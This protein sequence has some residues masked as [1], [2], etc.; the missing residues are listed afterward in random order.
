VYDFGGDGDEIPPQVNI[1]RTRLE[2][3]R[4][5][6]TLAEART[7]CRRLA[8]GRTFGLRNH[9]ISSCDGEYVVLSVRHRAYAA[10]ACPPNALAYENQ[11]KALPAVVPARP[12][13]P[14]PRAR[15]ATETATVVGPAGVEQYVDAFGRIK[16]QFHWDLRGDTGGNS[17]CWVRVAQSLA[18]SGWGAQ[19]IPRVGMEVVVTFFGGDLDR[20]L[21]THALYNGTGALPS[22]SCSRPACL[23][24]QSSTPLRKG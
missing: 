4:A 13:A 22:A 16:V 6:A 8:P 1:A 3:D 21:V 17:S 14:V 2:Q 7:V 23:T 18:G 12:P 19:F 15:H 11:I 20:P 10:A 24:A 9:H 5:H